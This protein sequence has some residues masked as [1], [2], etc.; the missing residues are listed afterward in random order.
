MSKIYKVWIEIEEIDEEEGTYE[1]YSTPHSV[2]GE[3]ETPEEAEALVASL[4]DICL[5]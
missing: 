1:D 3:F 5:T 4:L 2:G